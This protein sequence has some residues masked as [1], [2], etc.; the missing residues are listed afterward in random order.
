MTNS[1]ARKRSEE[2]A[3]LVYLYTEGGSGIR[4]YYHDLDCAPSDLSPSDLLVVTNA[5][6]RES[7]QCNMCYHK[8]YSSN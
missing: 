1:E 5:L 8:I 2:R 4:F 3:K 6:E 7:H